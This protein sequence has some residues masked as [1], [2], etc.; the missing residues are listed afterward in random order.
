V[1][2]WVDALVWI[3]VRYRHGKASIKAFY[4]QP[5]PQPLLK[6]KAREWLDWL[7]GLVGWQAAP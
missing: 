4:I 3:S 6:S 7:R 5:H 2:H 1:D